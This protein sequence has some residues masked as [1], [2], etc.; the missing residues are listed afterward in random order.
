MKIR[1]VFVAVAL[2][3]KLFLS[4]AEAAPSNKLDPS[5]GVGISRPRTTPAVA[6]KTLEKYRESDFAVMVLD[7]PLLAGAYLHVAEHM[8]SHIIRTN[9]PRD[10]YEWAAYEDLKKRGNTAAPLLLRL[11]AENYDSR[12]EGLIISM[13]SYTPEISPEPFLE[14]IR[15]AIIERGLSLGPT[16]S[17]FGYFLARFGDSSDQEL[18]RKWGRDRPYLAEG[19]ADLIRRT[20]IERGDAV[21]PNL[22]TVSPAEGT[23]S[24]P[25]NPLPSNSNHLRT[26]VFLGC[27]L[28]LLLLAILIRRAK[29]KRSRV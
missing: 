2:A 8:E 14:Y 19:I 9:P 29:T 7:D 1:V 15:K 22:P 18:L 23:N 21:I 10:D 5:P 3:S 11:C 27:V 13:V 24:G 26:P 16:W 20:A 25:P 17:Y 6:P 28:I 4:L 12:I